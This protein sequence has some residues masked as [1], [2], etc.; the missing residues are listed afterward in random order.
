MVYIFHVLG[1]DTQSDRTGGYCCQVDTGNLDLVRA[2]KDFGL[3]IA[4]SPNSLP[5][6][7]PPGVL[8]VLFFLLIPIVSLPIIQ[9]KKK[10]YHFSWQV[11]SQ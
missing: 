11:D 10:S 5:T 2:V 7:R 3:V 4:P 1:P 9:R 6:E 8:L